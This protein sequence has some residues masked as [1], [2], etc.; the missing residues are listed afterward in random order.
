MRAVCG[1][2]VQGGDAVGREGADGLLFRPGWKIVRGRAGEG[3]GFVIH[4]Q[5]TAW[6]VETPRHPIPF[7]DGVM[8]VFIS[9]P[10]I[11]TV[12]ELLTTEF[13]LPSVIFLT[14]EVNGNRA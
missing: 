13:K 9:A 14:R 7:K 4:T 8:E 3:R 2:A 5:T 12:R 1:G 10:D 6:T 11:E